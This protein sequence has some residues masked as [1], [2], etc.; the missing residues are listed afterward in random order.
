M[1]LSPADL[2]S[3]SP[4][5]APSPAAAE[6][7]SRSTTRRSRTTSDSIAAVWTTHEIKE[8]AALPDD[9]AALGQALDKALNSDGAVSEAYTAFADQAFAD[10]DAIPAASRFIAGLFAGQHSGLVNLVRTKDLLAALE[11]GS[12]ELPRM[13]ALR[14]QAGGMTQ[15]ISR[16]GES[17]ILHKDRLKNPVAAEVLAAFAGLLALNKP[18]RAAAL[19]ALATKIATPPGSAEF[20][21]DVQSWLSA[22]VL[23][24][25]LAAEDRAF[26]Q[27]HLRTSG[28]DVDWASPEARHALQSL[29]S[30]LR[31]DMLC[32]PLFEEAVPETWWSEQQIAWAAKA[33]AAEPIK[34]ETT[35]PAKADS[36]AP[37][38]ADSPTPVKAEPPAPAK[39]EP[40]A[41]AKAESPAPAKAESPAP[42]KT[43]PPAP[44]KAE[45]P[46]PAKAEPPA[47]AKAE[48][49][50][51][52]K[53]E[54][55][56]PAK[57]EP[58][59]P[60]KAESPAP[61]KASAPAA[62]AKD[63]GPAPVPAP[64]KAPPSAVL[65]FLTG[66]LL[67]MALVAGLW[68]VQPDLL[69]R[70]FGN[71]GHFWGG[72]SSAPAATPVA[73][74][75]ASKPVPVTPV[76]KA[77]AVGPEDAWRLQQIASFTSSH[78]AMKPW[79]VKAQTGNWQECE[80]LVSGRHSTAY[81]TQE[82]YSLYLKWLILDPPQDADMRR[83]VP[84]LYVRMSTVPDLLDLC[85]H[86]AY[87]GSPYAGDVTTMAQIALDIHTVLIKPSE[88]EHLQKLAGTAP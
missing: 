37:V 1:D 87:P 7:T 24:E 68:A 61:A 74:A 51:P 25:S 33:K 28:T 83:A 81:P 10:P 72:A 44:A 79:I 47:P 6:S 3:A 53:A 71:A 69:S 9:L 42:A 76:E 54:S 11:R 48:P 84:R 4:E 13:I 86:L 18:D 19:F 66:Q 16:F 62:S 63:E 67:G 38:K 36:P 45:P 41:P 88:H 59:A 80:Q 65:T 57:A 55:P 29:A 5:D 46:A 26:W 17:L 40:P 85:D 23:I 2:T 15:R 70:A 27:Q 22:G 49:Q 60:A 77:K 21:E 8:V 73:T 82:D 56:A 52:V 32:A 39:A 12:S 31:P 14:W 34:T 30:R 50:A 43:E 35:A 78:P 20:T 75:T 64:A 58:P